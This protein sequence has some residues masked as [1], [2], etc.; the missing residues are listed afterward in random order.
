MLKKTIVFTIFLLGIFTAIPAFSATIGVMEL[1]YGEVKHIQNGSTTYFSLPVKD[2]LVQEGDRF[3]TGGNTVVLLRLRQNAEQIR[4]YGN[5]NFQIKRQDTKGTNV[6]LN[7]GK[8]FFK[9]FLAQ[10]RTH[11]NV[12]TNTVAIGVK[13]TQF[14]V[15]VTPETTYLLTTEGTVSVTANQLP[16]L[17][18]LVTAGLA[19]KVTDGTGPTQPAAVSQEIQG[20]ILT[21]DDLAGFE[22]IEFG[23]VLIGSASPASPAGARQSGRLAAIEATEEAA[24]SAREAAAQLR[25]SRGNLL[26]TLP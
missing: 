6:F 1:I 5:S 13:G 26:I 24:G 16:A 21:T 10:H 3:L 20:E 15:G 7:F 23:P 8:A 17:T 9:A 25:D 11:F 12:I 4:L 18:T 19:S 22:K 14:V 2:V